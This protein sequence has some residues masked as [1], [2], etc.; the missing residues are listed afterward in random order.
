METPTV[1][2]VLADPCVSREL[3]EVLRRWLNR[4]PVDALN[5]AELLTQILRDRLSRIF[6][7]A[8]VA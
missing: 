3:K 1:D 6:S 7:D 2:S 8:G 5:D 4:D